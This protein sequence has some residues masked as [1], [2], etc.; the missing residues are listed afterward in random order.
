LTCQTVPEIGAERASRRLQGLFRPVDRDGFG[1][2]HGPWTLLVSMQLP[3]GLTFALLLPMVLRPETISASNTAPTALGIVFAIL[4]GYY[5]LRR[6]SS[7]PNIREV[8]SVIPVFT[9]SFLA[10]IAWFFFIRI[11]YSRFQFFGAYV[12]A[13]IWFVS[14]CAIGQRMS[15][16]NFCVVP[17]G[18]AP[19]I[20]RIPQANWRVI[21]ASDPPPRY[22]AG[23]VVD[24]RA[25]L[26]MPWQQFITACVLSGTPVYHFKQVRELLTGRLEI[27][28]L[29]E[30]I[31]GSHDP[32]DGYL[33]LKRV[34]DSLAALAAMIVLGPFMLLVAGLI[35]LDSKGPALFK[36]ARIKRG[37]AVF[38]IYKFRTMVVDA[39]S[40]GSREAAITRDGDRRIT[41]LGALL[42]RSRIDE[43]PQIINILKGEMSWI[44][45]RPEA[46]PLTQ[47]YQD[48]LPFYHYRHI[49]PPG[50]TG[51]AQV[52][53]GHVTD[54]EDVLDKLHYD[55]FYIKNFSIWLDILIVL[56]T[57]RTMVTGFGAR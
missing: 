29:S 8:G 12:L 40:S 37:G 56:K 17:V 51:W 26:P 11:E 10:V 32:H 42:R 53:Q 38:T 43:L 18:E 55:F 49:V 54:P 25:D 6:I 50:I 36:Q 3:G 20:C 4:I 41:R 31:L 2:A 35:R 48:R 34:F 7:F 21:E 5:A 46:V 44:G 1:T 15:R 13:V 22:C 52:N 30:N 16:K 47:W 24:L 39:S 28:H 14:L 9:L 27:E 57:L 23:V 45:P 19:S 33:K